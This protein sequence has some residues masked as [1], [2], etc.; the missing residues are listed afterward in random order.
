VV[1]RRSEEKIMIKKRGEK[2]NREWKRS[3]VFICGYN[4]QRRADECFL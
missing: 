4:G 1:W 3:K 2:E